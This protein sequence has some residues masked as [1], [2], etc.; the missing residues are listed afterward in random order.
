M[1][2]L[3]VN[4]FFNIYNSN[5]IQ[6]RFNFKTVFFEMPSS[7][8]LGDQKFIQKRKM[9]SSSKIPN[10]FNIFEDGILSF[11]VPSMA[12]RLILHSFTPPI[13][14]LKMSSQ[15]SS[16]LSECDKKNA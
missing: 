3:L 9:Q 12:K 11:D 7:P 13:K 10:I 2:R 1:E 4:L 14:Y 5:V 16:A 6:N 15:K 8:F